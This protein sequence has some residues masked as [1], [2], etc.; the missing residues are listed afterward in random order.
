MTMFPSGLS[1]GVL[2]RRPSIEIKGERFDDVSVTSSDASSITIAHSC[3]IMRV[4]L[5]DLI[6]SQRRS[7]EQMAHGAIPLPARPG[8]AIRPDA[9]TMPTKQSNLR[10][11]P[12]ALPTSTALGV[13]N[14]S[15]AEAPP[16]DKSSETVTSEKQDSASNSE[17][18]TRLAVILSVYA[19][20]L[21]IAIFLHQTRVITVFNDYTFTTPKALKAIMRAGVIAPNSGIRKPQHA[22]SA[23]SCCYRLGGVSLFDPLN[24]PKR[25]WIRRWMRIHKPLTIGIRLERERLA[26]TLLS[27]K[28]ARQRCRGGMILPARSATSATFRWRHAPA[29][30]SCRRQI[31]RASISS[32]RRRA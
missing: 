4:P 8:G 5:A 19:T 14:S 18:N 10:I 17:S 30:C 26:P 9:I 23:H 20:L 24:A 28:E 32:K 2:T 3:G 21:I 16:G 6:P 1:A 27:Y 25:N 13:P 15:I 29:T 11:E 12:A 7:L 31:R 22:M